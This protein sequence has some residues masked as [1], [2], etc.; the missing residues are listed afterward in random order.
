M[1]K[2]KITTSGGTKILVEGTT[3]EIKEIMSVL[4]S[5]EHSSDRDSKEI[6]EKV[7]KRKAD[8]SHTLTDFILSLRENE[9]FNKP[10]NLM[11]VKHSLEEQ[12]MIYPISTIAPVL[13]I[14]VRKRMLG[15]IKK[16][17]KWCYV[18]R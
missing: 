17:K 18:K 13:L 12:G 14:L 4:N 16:D 5:K 9:Y 15:R 11:E 10:R 8:R 7:D 2:A 6:L 3:E 1:A